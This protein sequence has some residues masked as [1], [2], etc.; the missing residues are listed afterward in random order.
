MLGVVSRELDV[1]GADDVRQ[2]TPYRW[3]LKE[4]TATL[5]K[6]SGLVEVIGAG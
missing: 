3:R 5:L 6:T 4:V 2:T 1:D